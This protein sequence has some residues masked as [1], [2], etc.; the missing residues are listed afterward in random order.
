MELDSIPIKGKKYVLVK[1][2]LQY[3]REHY[4]NGKIETEILHFDSESVMIKASA[5]VDDTLVAT[6]IAHEVKDASYIN[7]TSF[8]EVC[9]TSAIGRCLGIMGIGI[10]DSVAT[11]DEVNNA[12]KQQE[13]MEKVDELR[14]YKANTIGSLLFNAINEED[15]ESIV[16][17][18]SEMRG[19]KELKR[20][21]RDEL[22]PE[23]LHYLADRKERLAEERKTKKVEKIAKNQEFAKVWAAEE[24]TKE[25]IA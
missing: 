15:E 25:L 4:K 8:V 7:K 2:R 14:N 12:Q 18:L 23:H 6:G 21:V 20:L 13:A 17:L 5:Y 19:D 11:W 9:E 22:T 16:E 1:T 10:T 3:F 24:K